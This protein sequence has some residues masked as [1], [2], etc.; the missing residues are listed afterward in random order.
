M[1]DDWEKIKEIYKLHGSKYKLSRKQLLGK[2]IC[3]NCKCRPLLAG[4]RACERCK[5]A[6]DNWMKENRERTN[7]Y[8]RTRYESLKDQGL[9]HN[10]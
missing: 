6:S 2:G 3:P 4:Y 7:A 9:C 1:T 10:V 8:N 5:T